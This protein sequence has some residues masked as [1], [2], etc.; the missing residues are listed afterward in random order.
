MAN[1]D[2][3]PNMPMLTHSHNN[4]VGALYE[5]CFDFLKTRE[6]TADIVSVVLH[7]HDSII[8]CQKVPVSASIVQKYMIPYNADG[9]NNFKKVMETIE[10]IADNTESSYSCLALFMTD[11]NWNEDGASAVLK[12][13]VGKHC[14]HGFQLHSI[15]LGN[16][17]NVALMQQ[18]AT[19]GNGTFSKAGMSV[20]DL[21]R[22]YLQLAGL[23]K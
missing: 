20:I 16:D 2:A 10:N 7:H 6:G 19:I 3:T 4:R 15:V 17:I 5:A 8:V 21:K 1:R 12:R 23:L 22:A 13:V 11:G 14:A 18:F 9:D